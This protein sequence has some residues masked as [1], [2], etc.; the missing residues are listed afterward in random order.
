MVG[1]SA[2]SIA[3][4][5]GIRES[6]DDFAVDRLVQFTLLYKAPAENGLPTNEEF[7]VAVDIEDQ[8]EAFAI[9]N[10][11]IYV[12][13]LTVDGKRIFNT[14]LDTDELAIERI[15]RDIA[16]THGY[17]LAVTHRDD[18][19][20][21]GYWKELF[22][23]ADDWQMIQDLK[24]TQHLQ[25][26]GDSLTK[27]RRVDHWAYFENRADVTQFKEWLGE[28]QFNV[29]EESEN[30]DY[31]KPFGIQF[32]RTDLPDLYEINS[33]T[34]AIRKA[35]TRFSGTYDGWETSVERD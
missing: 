24:V 8:L 9:E 15:K 13:R 2:A 27:P 14:Y 26:N 35:V 34:F 28:Q 3:Y 18:P 31:P 7:D 32:F 11:G 20:K 4:D 19:E 30:A 33:V 23:T 10:G 16:A 5:H 6:I 29:H 21:Q 1:E 12:G 22:P 17:S 25:E